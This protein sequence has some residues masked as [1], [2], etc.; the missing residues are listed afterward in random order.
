[1]DRRSN[2]Q[3]RLRHATGRAIS[4]FGMIGDGDRVMVCVSGGKD[5]HTLLRIL[6][7]LQRRA[8]V[9]FDLLAVNLDQKQPGFPAGLL[10][11][12]FSAQGIPHRIVEKDTHSIVKAKLDEEETACSLC[13]RLRRGILYNIAVE[14]G[15]NKIA[16]GHHADDLIETLLLNLFFGGVLKTM[17]PLLRS[18]DGR[19]TVIRPLAYCWESE[20]RE[21]AAQEGFPIVPCG[22][23]GSQRELQRKR[24]KEWIA[25]KEAEIPRLRHSMLAALGRVAPSHLMDRE[26]FDFN[27]RAVSND[28]VAAELNA[29]LNRV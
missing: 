12:Y 23:C 26:L 28:E 7:E 3:R 10:A 19:N 22:L 15:C 24:I 17:P 25:R 20:I 18:S 9:R 2:L 21:Y 13:S 4:D 16:L 8:P 27:S 14:E 6:R 5:S 1:M 11:A 29:P